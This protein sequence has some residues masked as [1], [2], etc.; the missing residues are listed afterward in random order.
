MMT[1]ESASEKFATWRA[2]K[3]NK[4]T[5]VP[6]ELWNMVR[7][8]LST[9]KGA[10]LCKVLG[11]SSAQIKRHCAKEPT[12]KKQELLHQLTNSD[13]FVEAIAAP[14]NV[15][16]EVTIQGPSRS[17]HLCLPTSALREVLPVLG[18]LL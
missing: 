8:L 6:P 11:I 15:M 10:E 18:E 9:Y 14:T 12:L 1:L 4:N 3:T 5:A 2:T 7:D 16:S 13:D 17:L